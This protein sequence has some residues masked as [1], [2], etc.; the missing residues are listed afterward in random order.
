MLRIEFDSSAS[1]LV[2]LKEAE[3]MPS[4]FLQHITTANM[5]AFAGAA[6]VALPE[7]TGRTVTA[8]RGRNP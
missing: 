3:G 5:S 2:F 8:R 6:G 4:Q 7:E 1:C